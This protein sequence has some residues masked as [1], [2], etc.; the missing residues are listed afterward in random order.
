ML[1]LYHLLIA[2]TGEKKDSPWSQCFLKNILLLRMV[3]FLEFLHLPLCHKDTWHNSLKKP[4]ITNWSEICQKM[5]TLTIVLNE[6]K[7]EKLQEVYA[8]YS[9]VFQQNCILNWINAIKVYFQLLVSLADEHNLI[10]AISMQASESFTEFHQ[11]QITAI[12]VFS[13]S[14]S[15]ATKQNS[16]TI[17]A[18]ANQ[19]CQYS[20]SRSKKI[21]V[22]MFE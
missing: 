3:D 14:H 17:L 11:G 16:F 1:M 5:Y 20:V 12:K 18:A 8:E 19:N 22:S 4:N 21:L 2:R 6:E 13:C 7:P 15:C 10:F 9:V